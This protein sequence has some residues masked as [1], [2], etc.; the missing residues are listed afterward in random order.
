MEEAKELPGDSFT[1]ILILFI[2]ALLHNQ[3]TYQRLHLITSML[4]IRLEH[5]NFEGM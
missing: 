5:K 4:A 1:I 3:I 2:R